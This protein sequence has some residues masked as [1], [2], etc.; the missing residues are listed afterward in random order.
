MVPKDPLD[1]PLTFSQDQPKINEAPSRGAPRTS[2][3][4]IFYCRSSNHSAGG[5]GEGCRVQ[6]LQEPPWPTLD[7]W[8]CRPHAHA[9]LTG[10]EGSNL[11]RT[12]NLLF[13]SF[14]L[15][16]VTSPPRASLCYKI[17]PIR[18]AWRPVR[19]VVAVRMRA[20]PGAAAHVALE[21][22]VVHSA[23]LASCLLFLNRSFLVQKLRTET[24][25]LR[26]SGALELDACSGPGWLTACGQRGPATVSPPTL[27]DSPFCLSFTRHAVLTGLPQSARGRSSGS[28]PAQGCRAS[29]WLCSPSRPVPGAQGSLAPGP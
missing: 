1:L 26:D 20:V 24:P 3:R 18:S 5:V 28:A 27:D 21:A 7:K 2:L 12:A 10:A 14:V 15:G 6:P 22:Q 4:E 9:T 29:P 13:G 11:M 25:A 8:V 16:H 23:V 17:G 19:T